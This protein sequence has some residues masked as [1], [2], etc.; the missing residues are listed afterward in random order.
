MLCK[1]RPE[2]VYDVLA[3][4][5][6]HLDWGGARQSRDYR[7]VSLEASRGPATVGTTFTSTGTI[8]M[9]ARRW[10]D[11]STVSVADRPRTFEFTTEGKAGERHPMTVRFS[12][13]YEMSPEAGGS[14]VTYSLRQLEINNP[15]LRLGLPGIRQMTWRFAI[16]WFAGR[17]LRNLLAMAEQHAA[18]HPSLKVTV[19]EGALGL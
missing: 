19:K 8:P 18:Q 13:R 2:D 5:E 1:A 14:R 9:S 17:G 15:M 6:T 7:L 11:R 4:L 16:P 3:D 10:E 12:H